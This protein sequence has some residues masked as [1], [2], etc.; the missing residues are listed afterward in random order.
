[1]I[2]VTRE[3]G[4]GGWFSSDTRHR[5][6]VTDDIAVE[7]LRHAVGGAPFADQPA[8]IVSTARYHGPL[9]AGG[10]PALQRTVST[11]ALD[12]GDG[13]RIE[14]PGQL[15]ATVGLGGHVQAVLAL[16][17]TTL[18][19]A[20]GARVEFA[21]ADATLAGS[22]AAGTR[23]TEARFAGLTLGSATGSLDVG[24]LT[25]TQSKQATAHP[26]IHV[27]E[28]RFAWDGFVWTPADGPPVGF[29]D[30]QL[31]T[32]SELTG[33]ALD[34]AVEAV[35]DRVRT[36]VGE[37]SFRAH[38]RLTGLN[39]AAASDLVLMVQTGDGDLARLDTAGSERLL[40]IA[41]RLAAGGARLEL[42][43]LEIGTPHGLLQAALAAGFEPDGEVSGWSGLMRVLNG[44]AA[45]EAPAALLDNPAYGWLYGIRSY[46]ETDDET[47][48]L[49][50]AI[51]AGTVTLNGTVVQ[52]SP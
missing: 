10:G 38:L 30:G 40:D 18:S 35:A 47:A 24:R 33:N 52:G 5:I 51:D 21:G 20:N 27:G 7:R 31:T 42:D 22:L 16:Q 23:E 17:A 1:M 4:R 34:V 6:I 37:R 8:L 46:F 48:R 28:G 13:T 39:P 19:L 25:L 50:L 14:L 15:T 9:P 26:A 3:G 32:R 49:E 43:K 29:E 45:V 41:E 2:A 44:E 12:A 11:L 36:E